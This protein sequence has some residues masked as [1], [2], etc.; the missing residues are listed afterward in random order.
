MKQDNIEVINTGLT[1]RKVQTNRIV[2]NDLELGPNTIVQRRGQNDER[3]EKQLE[4]VLIFRSIED[5]KFLDL[6]RYTR[7]ALHK[8]GE[9]LQE[10]W[11]DEACELPED[12]EKVIKPYVN[13][14]RGR[15]IRV[16]HIDYVAREILEQVMDH[17]CLNK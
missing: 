6:T 2:H 5:I 11:Y 12:D 4:F 17:L 15:W 8:D 10:F 13:N 7:V 9:P 3:E 16:G 1:A 14:H